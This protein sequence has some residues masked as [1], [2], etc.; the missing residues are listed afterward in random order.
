MGLGDDPPSPRRG[1][2]WRVKKIGKRFGGKEKSCTFATISQEQH[3][4]KVANTIINLYPWRCRIVVM[5][6]N[7]K[8]KLL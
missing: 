2:E 1:N 4:F 7:K 8:R 6:Y 3:L 5:L